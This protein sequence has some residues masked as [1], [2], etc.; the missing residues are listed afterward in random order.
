MSTSPSA[1]IVVNIIN[2]HSFIWIIFRLHKF[3]I[4]DSGQL[5]KFEAFPEIYGIKSAFHS[6]LRQDMLLAI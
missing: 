2:F 1:K 4:I 5:A 3:K 6:K